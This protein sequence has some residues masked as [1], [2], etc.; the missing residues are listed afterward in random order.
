VE[1]QLALRE[2]WKP[3]QV[4]RMQLRLASLVT[5]VAG[6]IASEWLLASLGIHG[7]LLGALQ[8][9]AVGSIGFTSVVLHRRLVKRAV[10]RLATEAEHLALLQ[11]MPDGELVRVR[12][13]VAAR[14]GSMAPNNVVFDRTIFGQFVHERAVDFAL[15]NADGMEI[16]IDTEGA[17]LLH[18]QGTAEL[19]GR[20][21]IIGDTVEVLG[22]KDRRVDPSVRDRLD[23]DEPMRV[24][25][26]A[27]KALP[28]LIVPIQ[29]ALPPASSP[30]ALPAA[31]G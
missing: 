8:G 21:V 23:R 1:R 16:W 4:A 15:I 20:S 28:L 2:E 14:P 22:W 17:Q 10:Y 30:R 5:I 25:L 6:A 7:H 11:G 26:R 31:R 3:E 24:T 19:G 12:G 27:G 29:D 13:R 18:P 9:I